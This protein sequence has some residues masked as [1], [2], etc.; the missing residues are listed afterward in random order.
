M[1]VAAVVVV[2]IFGFLIPA[3]PGDSSEET[4]QSELYWNLDGAYYAENSE[5]AGLSSREPGEDG[6]YHI[7]FVVNGEQ[8]ELLCTDKQLVNY[9]DSL[10]VMGLVFDEN[11]YI[12]DALDV[13]QIATE[14]AKEFFV[15]KLE[16]GILYINSSRL[17]NGMPMEIPV[18]ENVGIYDMTL[19]GA[20]TGKPGQLEQ[21]D[22]VSV[23]TSLDGTKTH[24]FITERAPE[25]MKVYWRV[26]RMWDTTAGK[27]TR[28]PDKNGVYTM[29]F[30]CEGEVVELKCKDINIVNTID[31]PAVLTGQFAF[32][33]DEEG[34]IS[35]TSDVG[36][37]IRGTYLAGD[38]HVT[39]INGDTVTFTKLSAG[40]NQG[41]VVTAKFAQEYDIFQCCQ[42]AC[43]EHNCGE[44]VESLQ[45][46]DRVNV[47]A[48]LD[49]EIK[50]VFV[51][52]RIA[53]SPMYYNWDRQYGGN[54]E[55]GTLR[56][57]Q[58]GYYVFEMLCEGK[59]KRVKVKDKKM[60][61]YM[62]SIYNRCMGLKLEGDVVKAVY[63]A[64]CVYGGA[65]LGTESYVTSK[66]GSVVV[67][68]SAYSDSTWNSVLSP[69]CEV[70]DVRTGEYG[71][72]VGGKLEL[73]EG[74]Q[75]TAFRDINEQI[76]IVFVMSRPISGGK[77]YYNLQ[78]KYNT[79]EK[80]T[81]REPDEEGYYTYLFASEGKQ[82]T[83]K[84]KS[85]GMASF[86]DEQLAPLV[87]LKINKSGII[88]NAYS[89]TTVLKQSAK[90]CNYRYVENVTKSTFRT[91]YYPAET[92]DK[93][94]VDETVWQIAKNCV[95]YNVST[96][97]AEFRGEKTTLKNGDYIQ[98]IRD[99]KTNQI[100]QIW[101]MN[102]NPA[103]GV[104]NYDAYCD[105]CKKTVTW[106][107][108]I[109]KVAAEDKH[110]FLFTDMFTPQAIIGKQDDDKCYDV[111]LDLKGSTLN[112][113]GRC[114]LVYDK[115]TI[116][117]TKG[118]GKL[119]GTNPSSSG[120]KMSGGCIM[121]G[122]GGKL[123]ILGGTLGLG[124][125]STEF[126]TLAGTIYVGGAGAEVNMYGGTLLGGKTTQNG[127]N[128]GIYGGTF[129]LHS[130][131]IKGGE[132]P[133]GANIYASS[134]TIKILGGTIDGGIEMNAKTNFEMTGAPVITGTGLILPAGI[135]LDLT[136]L[137]T[138]ADITVSTTGIFTEAYENI[139]SY[140]PIFK[141]ASA[142]D[143]IV[144]K[145][146][147]LCYLSSKPSDFVLDTDNDGMAVC[148][149]CNVE[150]AW[151]AADGRL[152]TSLSGHYY[153][154]KDITD[155]TSQWA[156]T[157][158]KDAVLCIHMNGK[159]LTTAG[160]IAV[161]G[162]G[163]TIN[164]MGDGTITGRG[165]Y[166]GTDADAY[167]K[168]TLVATS[169]GSINLYDNVKVTSTAV[170][171]P[172]VSV[173]TGFTLNG[174][175]TVEATATDALA[176]HMERG[177]AS[178][179]GG[180][181]IGGVLADT[182]TLTLDGAA[183]V[184]ILGIAANAKL[185]VL[186]SFTGEGNVLF[187]NP[188][189]DNV[190]PAAN[191]ESTG[192]FTGKLYLF[193]ED[194]ALLRGEGGR[195]CTGDAVVTPPEPNFELDPDGDNM[196]VCPVCGGA[197]V[198]WTPV[199]AGQSIGAGK[200]GHYYLLADSTNTSAQ[201]ATTTAQNH[202]ICLHMNGKN[203]T[204]AGR[205]AIVGSGGNI[206]I[207]GKGNLT[208]TG[209]GQYS[210][211]TLVA[212][213]TGAISLYDDVTVT[214]SNAEMPVISIGVSTGSVNLYG[215]AK[216]KAYNGGVG[217]DAT[218]GKVSLNDAASAENIAIAAVS[219][220]TVNGNWTGTANV[221]FANPLVEGVVPAA[222]GTSTGAFTGTL[223][224]G[225][226]QLI[227]KDGGLVLVAQDEPQGE[228]VLDSLNQAECPVCKK[229]VTWTP[230]TAS[231]GDTVTDG[232]HYYLTGDYNNPYQF[233]TVTAGKTVC[234]HNNGYT[235][236]YPSRIFV[237]GATLNMMG[238]GSV[239]GKS[240]TADPNLGAVV[241]AW[242]DGY[243]NLYGGT[244]STDTDAP[245]LK[246]HGDSKVRVNVYEGVVIESADIHKG[247]LTLYG[248]CEIGTL[249]VQ[250][251]GKLVIDSTWTGNAK[252]TFGAALVEGVVPTANGASTGA[253]TGTLTMGTDKLIGQDG[254]LMVSNVNPQIAKGNA[255]AAAAAAMD[256][257]GYQT[258]TAVQC[259][260]CQK[261]VTWEPINGMGKVVA[262]GGHYYVNKDISGDGI[263]L[264][265][266]GKNVCVHL[267]GKTLSYGARIFA[268]SA[269]AAT[270][271]VLNLMGNGTVS[272]SNSHAD[273]GTGTIHA[274]GSGIINLYGGTYKSTGANTKATVHTTGGTVNIY[275][276]ATIDSNTGTN[277]LMEKGTVNLYGGTVKNGTGYQSGSNRLGG[278]V[279]LKSSGSVFNIVAGTITG[280]TATYGGNIRG[281]AGTTITMDGGL[282]GGT[283]E[284]G[285]VIG[286]A[287]GGGGNVN[288]NGTFTMNAGTVSGGVTTGQ[289]GNIWSKAGTVTIG[290]DATVTQGTAKEGGNICI[291]SDGTKVGTLNI[292]GTVTDGRTQGTEAHGGNISGGSNTVINITDGVISGGNAAGQGGNIRTYN[293]TINMTGG[294]IFGGTAAGA[295]N[296]NVWIAGS[297]GV[298][299]FTGGTV[300]GV[301]GTNAAGTAIYVG[302]D[303]TLY[304]G[305]TANAVR[306]DGISKGNI[307]T[308]NGK[309]YVL[310]DWTGTAS[311]KFV[312]SYAS[313][314]TVA[315]ASGQCGALAGTTFTPGGSYTGTLMNENGDAVKI[316]GVEGALVLA[317][318]TE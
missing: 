54:M 112:G 5:I 202:K 208:S 111:V 194:D 68:A 274:A 55:V 135:K 248:N 2:G 37:A 125:R 282:I 144:V 184:D 136:K 99:L 152:G 311:I 211:A 1:V 12:I 222:N 73:M 298:M 171:K 81:T 212:N 241:A 249:N 260:V 250:S 48:N 198:E 310:N 277:V 126:G 137:D 299:N 210:G 229:K 24:I 209:L 72:T 262:D 86:I 82:V 17:M 281:E 6:Y 134:G 162:S 64:V 246:L 130:G 253:F 288:I 275:S 150:V 244:Y 293:G 291:T 238:S 131:E 14:A 41:K 270:P 76:R 128:V 235:L 119:M 307:H 19:E 213:S 90:S 290:K 225:E 109:G 285:K 147:A 124:E 265:V 302:T 145:N 47:Y 181:V 197:E 122:N 116:M 143:Q 36:L 159:N 28:V 121:V 191:G 25:T 154:K 132:S 70:Y 231:L 216:V 91:F 258:G 292:S 23:Y 254:K 215:N 61:D 7:T 138:K 26:A 188:L 32:T 269:S 318:A 182:G 3:L 239:I 308:Y 256:F 93:K 80:T 58:G 29:E 175:A 203:L 263:F 165:S 280:G 115:L 187:E 38:F 264:T 97:V 183:Q 173:R 149:V 268:T 286:N 259:P 230:V 45:Y 84:T 186:K 218:K 306:D 193:M 316:L 217:I 94:K 223:T 315:A 53:D 172:V 157:T 67:L 57:K 313:G 46:G 117:D 170:G 118:G 219:K 189:V 123:D 151:T 105:H 108:Y 224:M 8:K 20:E 177:T 60:A 245:A 289:G 129:V 56:Q 71:K 255:V 267:N 283:P 133:L 18:D 199:E 127:G 273:Y 69:D 158:A 74:D 65:N 141:T 87:G 10:T 22:K 35:G 40:S 205:I 33:F 233:M 220:L 304:L 294:M 169:T 185:K 66:V 101:V 42:F 312:A 234:F 190:V 100:T 44:R 49:G 51:T 160:R 140:Q 240:T 192:A 206:N 50:L 196:A 251:T 27:T 77:V 43:Y 114:F 271:G 52:R 104:K 180:K 63:D 179:N 257:T 156:T 98:A 92:P 11:G 106:E 317:A 295:S 59:I 200:S 176:I 279:Y 300:K 166:T 309:F 15:K 107:P 276:G 214:I 62:D 314:A 221:T 266:S 85:K 75:V 120:T 272:S 88:T 178:L 204:T 243:V 163:G 195:L 30:A 305:G 4:V 261:D 161:V 227:G 9:I 155:N 34:Y 142:E 102:R 303:S 236:T 89:V 39:E 226:D 297:T 164:I 96:A 284:E 201:Y 174:N 95:I 103:Y 78:R 83:A 21:L 278:N 110:Y 79:A 167:T 31:S 16:N 242:A 139:A 148:P 287:T 153:L 13:K 237:T 207:M 168:A 252:A 247:T 232:G 296:H 113:D 301:D 228:L 146:N